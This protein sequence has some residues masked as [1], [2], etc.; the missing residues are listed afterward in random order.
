MAIEKVVLAASRMYGISSNKSESLIQEIL[1]EN[2]NI[3]E[4][5]LLKMIGERSLFYLSGV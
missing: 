1:G 5:E 3:S 4:G 2:R